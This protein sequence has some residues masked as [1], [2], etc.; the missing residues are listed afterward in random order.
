MERQEVD[1][2]MAKSVGYDPL[3]N[4]LEL[5]F[6]T[7]EIWQ[8]YEL[9]KNVYYEMISGSIGKYFQAHIKGRYRERRV[10]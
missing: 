6:K 9:P 7:G 10:G 3:T 4:T 8:Y 2:S 5:E 1:S